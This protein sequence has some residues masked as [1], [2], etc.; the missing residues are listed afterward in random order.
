VQAASQDQQG[1]AK[2]DRFGLMSNAFTEDELKLLLIHVSILSSYQVGAFD[3]HIL[4]IV[5]H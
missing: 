1:T 3:K 4:D 5:R 2:Q